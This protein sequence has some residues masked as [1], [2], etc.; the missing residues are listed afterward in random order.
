VAGPRQVSSERPQASAVWA[1]KY[2]LQLGGVD[3]LPGAIG[4]EQADAD[5]DP[6]IAEGEDPAVAGHN[7]AVGVADVEV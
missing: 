1:T 7:L 3:A 2:S 6:A 5:I 4:R